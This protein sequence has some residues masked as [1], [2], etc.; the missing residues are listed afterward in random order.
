[1]GWLTFSKRAKFL[2][3][4]LRRFIRVQ[5]F[6]TQWTVVLQAPLS[7]G[8]SKQEHWSGLSCP[9]PGT[10]L[11]QELNLRLYGS[12]TAGGFLTMSAAWEAL[13]LTLLCRLKVA[14]ENNIPINGCGCILIKLHLLKQVAR[15]LLSEWDCASQATSLCF[16]LL[17]LQREE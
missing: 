14:M 15:E 10:S 16:N 6:S 2:L 4:L 5:I 7:I 11:T 17:P 1:M 12:C 9:P 13:Q 8:F 3:L